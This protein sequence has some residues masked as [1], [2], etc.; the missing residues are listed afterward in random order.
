LYE[1][2]EFLRLTINEDPVGDAEYLGDRSLVAFIL[3]EYGQEWIYFSVYNY[4]FT[5]EFD[6]TNEYYKVDV[7]DYLYSWF[8]TFTC[9]S[10]SKKSAM[11]YV[12]MG[13][14]EAPIEISH[15]IKSF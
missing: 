7:T 13:P 5:S 8:Y 14:E 4:G 11:V 3:K 2:Q 12:Y 1:T 15:Q 9:Y 6:S 10:V